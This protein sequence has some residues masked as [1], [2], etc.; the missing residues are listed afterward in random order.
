MDRVRLLVALVVLLPLLAGMAPIDSA[1]FIAVM[2][3]NARQVEILLKQGAAVN[4][5]DKDGVTPLH[6]AA[7]SGHR[8]AVVE[9]LLAGGA[10]VDA[11]D[12]DANTPLHEAA[13]GKDTAII[14]EKLLAGGASVD[15]AD[16]DGKTPLHKAALGGHTAVVEKLLAGGASVDAADKDGKT[17]LHWV[18][19]GEDTAIV[20][21]LLAW[22]AAVNAA[23]K[24]GMTPLSYA[25]LMGRAV[26]VERLVA[27]GARVNATDK[28]GYTPLH[29][30]AGGGHTAVMER[31]LAGGADIGARDKWGGVVLHS[32]AEGGHPEVVQILLAHDAYVEVKDAKGRTPLDRARSK[33]RASVVQL[34]EQAV[35]Q[36]QTAAKGPASSLPIPQP[37]LRRSDVDGPISGKARPRPNAYALVVG[38]ETYRN[39]L[40]KADYAA[41]DAKIMGEYLTNVMG[42]QA[43]NVAA[44]LNERAAKADIEKYIEHWLPNHVEPDA[45]V[46]V[47]FSGHGAP[48][49]KTGE[50]YLVPYDGDPAFMEATGYPLTRLYEHLNKLPAR[51]VLVV[52]DSCFS[53][54][55]GRSVIAKG[56][57]PIVTEV[58]NPVLAKGKAVV[59]AA[60]AGPQVSSTY[61]EKGHGLLT[62]FFLKGLQGEGDT[63]K[64]G[65]IEL[66]ELFYYLKPQVER[67]ARRDFNNEQT[68]QLLGSSVMLD[69]GVRLAERARP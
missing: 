22:R 63:N 69:R 29:W 47:Y 20:D 55:G 52:L 54:A 25:A 4:A 12:K 51:E 2:Q 21:Q 43:Q 16:K 45:A 6:K 7:F 41:Q 32:A 17:P 58:E 61:E 9:K 1:L 18:A 30:A 64:D 23:D 15:A 36:Q 62:Y 3:G 26:V 39:D 8:R 68:P 28:D 38:V 49:P 46:F 35:A 5:A 60:S 34:L 19:Y 48:N 33:G 59:L 56:L 31:L 44:L 13:S 65:T 53:G 27:G 66:T 40:P 67:V 24:D 10:L 11:A 14:V 57:W 50:A 42:Y 37:A